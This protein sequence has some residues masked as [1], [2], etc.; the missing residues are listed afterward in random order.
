[1]DPKWLRPWVGDEVM[2]PITNKPGD[3]SRSSYSAVIEQ[4]EVATAERYR[5]R[6]LD[7]KPGDE[8]C[9]NYFVRDVCIAMGVGFAPMRANS[10]YDYLLKGQST[11]NGW[12]QVLP[13]IARALAEAGYPVI[14]AWENPLGPGHVGMVVPSRSELDKNTTFIAQAGARNFAYGRLEDGF[15]AGK[16]IAFFAHP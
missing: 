1:M 7:K 6:D 8:T 3:R 5:K 2:P 14:A 16:P 11:G 13:W 12:Y 15:G 4:F 10:I 9:C